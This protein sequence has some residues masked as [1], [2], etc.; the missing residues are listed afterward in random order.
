M[1]G[2]I[3]GVLLAAGSASRFGGG[4]L[5][6]LLPD[7]TPIG[8]A[9][10]KHLAAVVDSVVAVVRPQDDPLAAALVAC[11]GRVTRCP[12]AAEGIGAS[13]A[14]GVRAAPVAAA[15]LIALA[16][17]PWV[18]PATMAGVVDALRRG[19][20]IAAPSRLGMRG[21]PVGFAAAC[22]AELSV[23]SGDEGAR[24]VLARHEVAQI[25]TDDVGILRDVDTRQDLET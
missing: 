15:W 2:P 17:M 24:A 9:A 25:D 23:L 13:L 19:A 6:A 20:A 16:D 7:G 11:G 10:L 1:R 21:H 5:L 3:V 18:Q 12:Q 4:K 22:Y 14:W 8:V